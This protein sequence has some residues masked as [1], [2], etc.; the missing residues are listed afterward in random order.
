MRPS[1]T[2]R[3]A[4]RGMRDRPNLETQLLATLEGAPD[5]RSGGHRHGHEQL[6]SMVARTAVSS[7]STPPK[8]GLP[9]SREPCLAGS[10]S[11]NPTISRCAA[12][13]APPRERPS[14]RSPGAVDDRRHE[15][16]LLVVPPRCLAVRVG[17]E[18]ESAA[19]D[20]GQAKEAS[21]RR[22]IGGTRRFRLLP[23]RRGQEDG[24]ARDRAR[25]HGQGQREHLLD[26][27]VAP[28]SAIEAEKA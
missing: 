16:K 17:P 18:R 26:R 19:A 11:M 7:S 14:R 21:S 22:S 10:S 1:A 25:Q 23:R 13:H 24:C 2:R 12:G 27:G 3:R 28:L 5:G 9:S 8:T 6:A 20:Q 4:A 15:A